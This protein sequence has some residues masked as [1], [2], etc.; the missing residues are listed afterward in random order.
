MFS[1]GLRTAEYFDSPELIEARASQIAEKLATS[2]H[3][4]AFCGAGLSTMSGIPDY[5]SGYQTVLATGPGK[6]ESD[7]N[8]AK[9]A[10]KPIRKK[11]QEAWPNH[12][13][14]ALAT[15]ANNGF[16]KF[17]ISQNVDGLLQRAGVKE[18]QISELHGNIFSEHCTSCGKTYWRDFAIPDFEKKIHETGRYCDCGHSKSLRDSLIYFGDS[19]NKKEME[20]CNSQIKHADFCLVLG[21]SLQVQPASHYV[22]HFLKKEI[23]GNVAIV[24]LQKTDYHDNG[25]IEVHD[26]CD[27]FLLKVVKKLGLSFATS[28]INRQL[29]LLPKPDQTSFELVFLDEH[30]RHV[31]A[32]HGFTLV[33]TNGTKKSL[34][35]WPFILSEQ[36]LIDYSLVH[37]TLIPD[38]SWHESCLADLLFEGKQHRITYQPETSH[39]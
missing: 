34:D 9:Y 16:I 33:S 15:L 36:D 26:Y 25:A 11:A 3:P 18:N 37:Y 32:C 23:Q 24:N 14:L 35:V 2:K 8:K 4:I 6:W 39:L 28:A 17:V 30:G 27:K 10:K 38:E 20:A 7:E 1:R 5:R 29:Y 12:G 31:Q 21:S 13:H 22:R 19:L